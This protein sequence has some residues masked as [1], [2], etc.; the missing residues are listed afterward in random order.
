MVMYCEWYECFTGRVV[1]VE[2][3]FVLLMVVQPL[4]EK[5]LVGMLKAVWFWAAL[6]ECAVRKTAVSLC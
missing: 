3:I 1:I 4:A 6:G 5:S 2:L